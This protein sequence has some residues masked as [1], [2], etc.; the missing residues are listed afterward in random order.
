M[1]GD[2]FPLA[3]TTKSTPQIYIK[4]IKAMPVSGQG[5]KVNEYAIDKSGCA[6]ALRRNAAQGART[7]EFIKHVF[8]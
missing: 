8:L 5:S 2:S 1:G 6:D 4:S 3:K 7:N